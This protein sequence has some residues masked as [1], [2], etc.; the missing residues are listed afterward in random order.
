[1]PCR[2]RN[3][4]LSIYNIR[5]VPADVDG[6]T[7]K[8]R[9]EDGAALPSLWL[10]ENTPGMFPQAAELRQLGFRSRDTTLAILN[11]CNYP[12][13]SSLSLILA[14]PSGIVTRS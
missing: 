7:D 14:H 8:V 4:N 5:P 2:H 9:Q 3:A 13:P 12:R 1:M 11:Q 6:R 10:D